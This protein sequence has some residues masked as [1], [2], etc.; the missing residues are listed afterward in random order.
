[1]SDIIEILKKIL[2]A[3]TKISNIEL[4]GDEVFF[5]FS[6]KYIWSA[7]KND[8]NIYFYFY[9]KTPVENYRF[10]LGLE[11]YE[12]KDVIMQHYNSANYDVTQ[13]AIFSDLYEYVYNKGMGIEDAFEDILTV[14]DD[15]FF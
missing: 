3:K 7:K 13:K 8:G 15:D 2:S 14:E 12:F 10:L 11:P 1:M 4:N 9:P 6:G 5:I